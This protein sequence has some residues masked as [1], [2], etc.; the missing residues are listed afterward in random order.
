[1]FKIFWYIFIAIIITFTL[2]WM[3]DNNGIVTILWLNHEIK[4]DIVTA[5]CFGLIFVLGILGIIYFLGK[6]FSIKLP[7]STNKI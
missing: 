6:L 7:R 1:M 3:L 4:T 5:L 2:S